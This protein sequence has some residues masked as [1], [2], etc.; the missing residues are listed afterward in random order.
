MDPSAIIVS[1]LNYFKTPINEKLSDFK[2]EVDFFFDKGLRPYL[3]SY[4]RKYFYTKTFLH[5]FEKQKFYDLYYPLNIR[6]GNNVIN[7]ASI[8]DIFLESNCVTIIGIAGS[9]K[10]TLIKHLF[11]SSIKNS[12]RIPIL[13]ELRRVMES[14]KGLTEY[15]EKFIFDSDIAKSEKILS[16]ILKQG[17]FIF[18]F[19]GYDE[20]IQENKNMMTTYIE[21]FI[22]RY[23]T[24]L[25]V[26]TSRPGANVELLPRFVNYHMSKFTDNDIKLYISKQVQIWGARKE[27]A[28]RIQDSIFLENKRNEDYK[29][30]LRTPLLLSMYI[31][32]FEYNSEIP[33]K[34]SDFYANVFITLARSHNSL[35]KYG[36]NHEKKS[37]L[38]TTQIEI[39]LSHL[40]FLTFRN[41]QIEFKEHELHRLLNEVQVNTI[42]VEFNSEDLIYDLRIAL[43]IIILDGNAYRFPHRSIQEYFAALFISKK[44]EKIKANIYTKELQNTTHYFSE[45]YNFWTLCMELDELFFLKY[46]MLNRL[47]NFL[48]FEKDPSQKNHVEVFKNWLIKTNYKINFLLGKPGELYYNGCIY[49]DNTY[50]KIFNFLNID[51]PFDINGFILRVNPKS[52][53]FMT[54]DLG[55][56]NTSV[57]VNFD[58]LVGDSFGANK[59]DIEKGIK[60]FYGEVKVKMI[61]LENRINDLATFNNRY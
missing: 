59:E 57:I 3:D 36:W 30:L 34:K 11:L 22:D 55:Y 53:L 15:I 52:G 25:F 14:S 54:N 56:K 31:L 42:D 35:S 47:E 17:K 1:L 50:Y 46:Y 10:S 49:N 27:L 44:P 2:K 19:D 32:S 61:E 7:V 5:R 39:V 18:L 33:R 16:R 20:L 51:L 23:S 26:L 24:N 12:F 29:S 9:G 60:V 40:S 37:K 13:V 45:L 21:L 43:S 48:I 6:N 58:T 8:K 28:K 38:D 41:G 4:W